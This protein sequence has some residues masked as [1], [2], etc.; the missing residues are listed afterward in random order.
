MRRRDVAARRVRELHRCAMRTQ[1]ADARS[2][3]RSRAVRPGTKCALRGNLENSPRIRAVFASR[4]RV[5]SARDASHARVSRASSVRARASFAAS[6]RAARHPLDDA[7]RK[8][9]RRAD[10]RA[11]LAARPRRSKKHIDSQAARD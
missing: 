5:C 11:R 6:R 8:F 4:Q 10:G 1:R 2:A 9:F 3:R 7:R